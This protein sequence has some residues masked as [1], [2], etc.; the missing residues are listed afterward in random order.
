VTATLSARPG[1]PGGDA[2]RRSRS[3]KVEAPILEGKRLGVGPCN[4][5]PR[6]RG[7]FRR[8][9]GRSKSPRSTAT[10]ARAEIVCLEAVASPTRWPTSSRVRPLEEAGGVGLHVIEEVLAA[11]SSLRPAELLP[12]VGKGSRRLRWPDLAPRRPRPC[13][14]ASESNPEPFHP[15]PDTR[16]DSRGIGGGH[17]A[18]SSG[19]PG[20]GVDGRPSPA[21]FRS[22]GKRTSSREAG[23]SSGSLARAVVSWKSRSKGRRE[24]G[25]ISELDEGLRQ[26]MT[27][28]PSHTRHYTAARMADRCPGPPVAWP[29]HGSRPRHR[30][31]GRIADV[32]PY[33]SGVDDLPDRAGGVRRWPWRSALG[34]P[35]PDQHRPGRGSS[36]PASPQTR[37]SGHTALWTPPTSTGCT[38]RV[39][40]LLVPPSRGCT[41]YSGRTRIFGQ[42]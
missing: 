2:A 10:T 11:H 27:P 6:A 33:T 26:G 41:S 8:A 24:A 19:R 15:A 14:A 25:D 4:S 13:G 36:T 23:L 12:L 34:D 38:T 39:A 42:L 29:R 20:G 40:T 22:A 7:R 9:D 16:S 35:P 37:R 32:R 3:R 28:K 30:F 21:A 17:R 5:Q 31:P 18:P 1:G